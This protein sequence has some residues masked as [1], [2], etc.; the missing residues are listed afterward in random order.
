MTLAS[1]GE[2]LTKMLMR[3]DGLRFCYRPDDIL[4][5]KKTI[6][7]WKGDDRLRSLFLDTYIPVAGGKTSPK[8]G[9]YLH[10]LVT[11]GVLQ[12]CHV[13]D[14]MSV[15]NAVMHGELVSSWSTAEEDRKILSLS[16]LVH[17]LTREYIRRKVSVATKPP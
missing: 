12:E 17:R 7:E 3:P 6:Q 9:E 10:H 4:S 2:G 14:W 11:Q 5:L 1:A 8:S 13:S 16:D 15:R